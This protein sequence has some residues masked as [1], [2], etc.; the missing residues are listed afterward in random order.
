MNTSMH[1]KKIRQIIF[2]VGEDGKQESLSTDG[3]RELS[4]SATYHGD[5]DE[6]WVISKNDG[7]EI[8]RFNARHIETIVWHEDPSA[9]T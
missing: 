3:S 1:G 5:R 4:M 9:P 7:I 8:A 2:P 6:F